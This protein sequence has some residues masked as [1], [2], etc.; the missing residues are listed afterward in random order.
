MLRLIQHGRLENKRGK[1]TVH[2]V[3]V[4]VNHAAP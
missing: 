3:H 2:A 4:G 1:E